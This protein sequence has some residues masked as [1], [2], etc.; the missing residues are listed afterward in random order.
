MHSYNEFVCFWFENNE[1]VNN[2]YIIR[3]FSLIASV[4]ELVSVVI[5]FFTE[6]SEEQLCE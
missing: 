4:A 6:M 5:I 3:W 1:D 2:P